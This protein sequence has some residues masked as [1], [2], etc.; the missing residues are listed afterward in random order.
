[1]TRRL[2]YFVAVFACFVAVRSAE[3]AKPKAPDGE[4]T[5]QVTPSPNNTLKGTTE[6]YEDTITI[7]DGKLITAVNAKYGFKPVDCTVKLARGKTSVVAELNDDK[8][9]K[10]EF[11]L[12]FSGKGKDKT[13]DVSGQMRWGKQ[14]EDGNIKSAEYSVTGTKN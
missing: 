3:A 7:K 1:M 8:H 5:V 4:W 11:Q 13:T 12:L 10:T 9:G 2:S 6:A 14:G